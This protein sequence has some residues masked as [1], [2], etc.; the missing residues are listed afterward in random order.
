MRN[1]IKYYYDLDVDELKYKNQEYYF[2]NYILKELKKN[3]DINLYNFFIS[4]NIYIHRIIYNVQGNYI[5]IIDN[6]KFILLKKERSLEINMHEIIKFLIDINVEEKKNWAILWEHKVDY[7]EKNI[8][9]LKNKECLT[10]F[11][12]YIGLSELAIRVC[13]EAGE[14]GTYSVCHD[15]LTCSDLFYS[16]D[17]IIIDYKVRDIAEYIKNEFFNNSLD[18]NNIIESLNKLFLNKADYYLLYARL[19]F[20]TYFYDCI[21]NNEN[22][23]FYI[24]KINQYEKLLNHI[25]FYL[26]TKVN[27]PKIDW[28]IKKV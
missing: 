22:I 5:T 23:N 20:P 1:A 7:Y 3:I 13:K 19:L 12:Y 18:F 14:Y 27:M 6:K 25:Y 4:N 11:P 21:E 9:R 8:I 15:R 24:D 17:N 28:L 26:Q 16:P 2:D 10:V